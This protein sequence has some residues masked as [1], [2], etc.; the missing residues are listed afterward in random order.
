MKFLDRF[1]NKYSYNF[2][3]ICGWFVVVL[4]TVFYIKASISNWYGSAIS[5]IFLIIFFIN[6]IFLLIS[7]IIY[8]FEEIFA[9]KIKNQDFLNNKFIFIFQILGSV[10]A[11]L[12]I[13]YFLFLLIK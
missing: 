4:L 7:F 12:P 13:L 1:K 3:A 11:I 2:L 5:L 9:W 10:F 8:I 6:I